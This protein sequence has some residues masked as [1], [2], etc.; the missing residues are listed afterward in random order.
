MFEPIA[1]MFKEGN[2]YGMAFPAYNISIRGPYIEWVLLAAAEMI[3]KIER[4]KLEGTI[5]ELELMRD[6][7][8]GE[9]SEIQIDAARYAAN[10]RFEVVPQCI[11]TMHDTDYRW[12]AKADGGQGMMERLLDASLT[13]NN[14]FL[15]NSPGW[16]TA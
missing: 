3:G 10:N 14:T 1:Q 15:S 16:R 9:D 13:R 8:D 6:F 11:V 7:A 12:V 2:R 5:E 4:L